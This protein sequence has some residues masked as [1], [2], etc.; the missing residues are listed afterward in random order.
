MSL[1]SLIEILKER[2]SATEGQ[3]LLRSLQQDPFVW[4]FI[5]DDEDSSRYFKSAASKITAFTPGKIAQWLIAQTSQV[6]FENLEDLETSLPKTV[7]QRSSQIFETLKNTSLPPSD[8]ETAGLLGLVLREKRIENGSW[9]GICEEIFIT[10]DQQ[11]IFKNIQRWQTAF[12][13]LRSYCSDFQDLI[14]V[15]LLSESPEIIKTSLPIFIHSYLSN[16]QDAIN[17]LDLTFSMT[18]HLPMNHQLA[19]LKYLDGAHQP[20]LCADLAMNLIQTKDNLHAFASIFSEVENIE[21]SNNISEPLEKEIRYSLPEDISRIAAFNYFAG[22]FEKANEYYQKAH[23]VLN[24]LG[25]QAMYQSLQVLP[26]QAIPTH[27]LKL[28]HTLPQSKQ[29]RYFYINSLI[30][31]QQFSEAVKCIEELNQ[32]TEKQHLLHYV[33]LA[34]GKPKRT[35]KDDDSPVV[36]PLLENMQIS[37]TTNAIEPGKQLKRI[38]LNRLLNEKPSSLNQ[39]QIEILLEKQFIDIETVILA[40]DYY[41]NHQQIEKAIELSAYLKTIEPDDITHKRS[42][43][44][45]FV[46]ADK[47]LEAFTT[48][49]E[50]IKIQPTPSLV[51][52]EQF[53]LSALRMGRLDMSI[54][55]SQNILKQDLKNTKALVLLGEAYMQKGDAVKAIQ[56]MEQVVEMIPE[57]PETWLSLARLW[58]NYGQTDRSFEILNQGILAVP[59]DPTLLREIGKAHIQQNAPAD[60]M[61]VLRKAYE[62]EPENYEGKINLARVY[63]QLGQYDN[64]YQLLNE[65]ERN[66][67]ADPLAAKLLGLVLVALN[68]RGKAK[69]ILLSAATQAPADIEAVQAAAELIID[70]ADAN[71][72]NLD[73][74][75][76]LK[77]REILDETQTLD[78]G[79]FQLKI[80]MADLDRLQGNHEKAMNAYSKLTE[81]APH[82]EIL[83]NWRLPFGLGQAALA[84][85]NHDIGLAALQD[86]ISKQPGN[87]TI[88][89]ALA[90]GYQTAELFNK[91][92]RLADSALKSAPQNIENILWYADFKLQNNDPEESIR[93]LKDALIIEPQAGELKLALTKSLITAGATQDALVILTELITA[94]ETKP[95]ELHQAA[96][97]CVH[98]NELNMAV[99]ALERSKENL[100]QFEPS[101]IMD[102]SIIYAL[103]E[104]AQ[105][106]LSTLDVPSEIVVS[107]P[108]IA[109]LKADILSED[110]RFQEALDILQTFENSIETALKSQI[111][112]IDQ[113]T[114]SPLLYNFDFTY[115]G[116]LYRLAQLQCVLGD[117]DS[118]KSLISDAVKLQPQNARYCNAAAQI[119]L[120]TMDFDSVFE[121]A[122]SGEKLDQNNSY[123]LDLLC[124]QV[125]SYLIQEQFDKAAS[126]VSGSARG[127]L[128]N[129]RLSAL[130]SSIAFHSGDTNLAKD[131]LEEGINLCDTQSTPSPAFSLDKKFAQA[132]TH[133]S[134]AQAAIRLGKHRIALEHFGTALEILKHQPLIEWQYAQ[135]I[136][137]SAE[138]QRIAEEVALTNHAPGNEILDE[139]YLQKSQSLLKALNQVLSHEEL[140]C[141]NARAISAF[142]GHWP[143]SA[144]TEMCVA[145]PESASAIILGSED[146]VLIKNIFETFPENPDILRAYGIYALRHHDVTGRSAVKDALTKDISDPL[147]HA[148]L[149]MLNIEE[150]ERALKS[151]ETALDF[152]PDEPEW[153]ALA[154]DLYAAIGDV[155]AAEAHINQAIQ[156]HPESATFWQKNAD[157]QL[158]Q[159]DLLEAKN[160]LEKSATYQSQNP[161]IW[162]KLADL[163]RRMGNIADAF[164]NMETAGKLSPDDSEIA[165]QEARFLLEQHHFLEAEKKAIHLLRQEP[166]NATAL[167]ILAKALSKQ[168][169]VDKALEAL[170]SRK[171]KL[172]QEQKIKVEL[173][174]LE[175]KKDKDGYEAVL[176]ELIDF[177]NGHPD[178]PQILINL[179]DWLIHTN[180][181]VKAEETAQ[182][183][184]KIFPEQAEI[185]LMLGRLKRKKGQLD[186]AI[187][188][189]SDA[190]AHNP[191]LVDAYIEL[192]KTYQDRRN[193]E[194]A[195]KVFQK[196]VE[197]NASDPRLYYHTGM[198][199]KACKDYA[200]AEKMLREA[201]KYSPDDTNI[202]R[203]LGVITALNLINNLREVR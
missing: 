49:Q 194:E 177:A 38:F 147:N 14:N 120:M 181:L 188:H 45:L 74:T 98:L 145:N 76:L 33:N 75:S 165:E 131:W 20:V 62:I 118:T 100:E 15:T 82:D 137:R 17:I 122:G 59:N 46:E 156:F 30:E 175:I 26:E 196:G 71:R 67:Q 187:S 170:K 185:H 42:L 158:Q 113:A 64:A 133:N 27:W 125:E 91:A 44:K 47:W 176:P 146:E 108:Q 16:S 95:E 51:D 37:P 199:L 50:I 1:M 18:K 119:S 102:L 90:E 101:I 186:Q 81:T 139:E 109:L 192:G 21:T 116:Y 121:T 8:L 92:D 43:V 174:Y 106:A 96:Y 12:A 19:C 104:D 135:G 164:T 77:I 83:S 127:K 105:K 60:A 184:L 166:G 58:E 203:Q 69:P 52:L 138:F 161:K 172:S 7:K 72:Q 111:E 25:G 6:S 13:C 112:D 178:Q 86:A 173:E 191:S 87:L 162:I 29:A 152:W 63:Y 48:S 149:A 78:F 34:Q 53:S 4:Q 150:P 190:V 117:I 153:H 61:P 24:Y 123:Q 129:S 148:L 88:L 107:Y 5:L 132:L 32:S 39:N 197:I 201:K 160:A 65:F 79:N 80:A 179:T 41:A 10:K 202:I 155:E 167:I 57:E 114:K 128:H 159:N 136:I 31:N 154:A 40:R 35:D 66:Y 183:A 89:H 68:Q 55:I 171:Q 168:G 200:N 182:T 103:L 9:K 193:L 141:L 144:N 99:Q 2:F 126:L 93:A 157:I 180:R 56:H 3:M 130:Q 142:T 70:Q 143:L 36:L 163:N 73:N 140:M 115:P 23:N 85:G 94:S 195:I 22:N 97:T 11:S 110:N 84:T 151:L 28:I 124:N 169:K 54:S 134:L 189:L 198:A